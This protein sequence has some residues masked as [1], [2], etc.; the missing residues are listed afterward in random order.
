[1]T[2][3]GRESL[4][5]KE[6]AILH[7]GVFN[8]E[9]HC[10]EKSTKLRPELAQ[11]SFPATD[12]STRTSTT[13]I[14]VAFAVV[15]TLLL[16]HRVC[17]IQPRSVAPSQSSNRGIASNIL[18]VCYLQ[19]PSWSNPI[20]YFARISQVSP[21]NRAPNKVLIQLRSC[22]TVYRRTSVIS[23]QLQCSFI[24]RAI[25]H[26]WPKIRTKGLHNVM[27]IP[28]TTNLSQKKQRLKSNGHTDSRQLLMSKSYFPFYFKHARGKTEWRIDRNSEKLCGTYVSTHV[29]RK[30]LPDS[31]RKTVFLSFWILNL[32]FWLNGHQILHVHVRETD[33]FRRNLSS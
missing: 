22:F 32:A 14:V 30:D 1:V 3:K 20:L 7:S 19:V 23:L 8:R 16:K 31:F 10:E 25:I 15:G 11:L 29:V 6:E 9:A 24:R 2:A 26:W 12:T 17:Q 5:Y 28:S 4:A 21:L 33:K 27:A 13:I 18:C